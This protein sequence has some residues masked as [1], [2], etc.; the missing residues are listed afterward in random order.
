MTKARQRDEG[1]ILEL[2]GKEGACW[3]PRAQ[4]LVS[5]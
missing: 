2:P 5:T 4:G 3:D 1:W